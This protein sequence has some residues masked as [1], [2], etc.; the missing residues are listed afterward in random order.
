MRKIGFQATSPSYGTQWPHLN[1]S[2]SWEMTPHIDVL[3]CPYLTHANV[4]LM[5]SGVVWGKPQIKP[6]CAACVF[7][8]SIPEQQRGSA[9]CIYLRKVSFFV[10]NYDK[11]HIYFYV[12]VC[13]CPHGSFWAGSYTILGVFVIFSVIRL[14]VY[15]VAIIHDE[16][17]PNTSVCLSTRAS[18]CRLC[19]A[20]AVNVA[21][22]LTCFSLL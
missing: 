2:C 15:G 6:G 9:E 3:I 13:E 7:S 22:R 21:S 20:S 8:T 17:K 11:K 4:W 18:C 14:R 16:T 10:Q 19:I 12:L 1:Q 5:V